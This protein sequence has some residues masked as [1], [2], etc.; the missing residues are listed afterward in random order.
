[1]CPLIRSPLFYG[2]Q[3]S[4]YATEQDLYEL[5]W[6]YCELGRRKEEGRDKELTLW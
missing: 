3:K 1:V 4:G 6:R 5:T 2:I